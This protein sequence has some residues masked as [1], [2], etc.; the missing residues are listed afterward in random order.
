MCREML[1]KLANAQPPFT[2]ASP[3]Q[4]DKVRLLEAAGCVKAFIRPVHIGPDDCARLD[5]AKVA[6]VT[7]RGRQ[8]L[9]RAS[10][11]RDLASERGE[12]HHAKS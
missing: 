3:C 5:P 4:I 8:T 2:T 1:Q 6:E 10:I 12:I 11:A 9:N 7:A